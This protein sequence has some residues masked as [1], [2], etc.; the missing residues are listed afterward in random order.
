MFKTHIR[1]EVEVFMSCTGIWKTPFPHIHTSLHLNMVRQFSNLLF[2]LFMVYLT[3]K[4]SE[5]IA[6]WISSWSP[7]DF[8]DNFL[9]AQFTTLFVTI[10]IKDIHA[11]CSILRLYT[12]NATFWNLLVFLAWPPWFRCVTLLDVSHNWC[13]GFIVGGDAI[14]GCLFQR[15][16]K[17]I[18]I[19][20][21]KQQIKWNK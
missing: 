15:C 7:L 11:D 13:S 18:R 2:S 14:Q 10:N 5:V 3:M 19:K 1:Q 6:I 12:M 9:I 17:Y 21:H 16:S 8:N 20:V 4:W